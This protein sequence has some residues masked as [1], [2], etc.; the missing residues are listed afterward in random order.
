MKSRT[1]T[2]NQ[3]CI[4]EEVRCS[5]K[6]GWN[7]KEAKAR[8]REIKTKGLTENKDGSRRLVIKRGA[9]NEAVEQ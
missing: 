2:H 4:C 7:P 5:V 3:G 9:S 6:C 1:C 8:Q